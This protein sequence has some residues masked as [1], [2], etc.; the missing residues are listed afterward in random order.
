MYASNLLISAQRAA[1]TSKSLL[2]RFRPSWA[3]PYD[4]TVKAKSTNQLRLASGIVKPRERLLLFIALDGA[5]HG[6]DP[7]RLQKGMFLFAMDEESDPGEV[8]SFVPYNYGPMSAQI[9]RDLELLAEQGLVEAKPVHGQSWARYTATEDGLV[10]ARDLLRKEPSE[11][12]AR[13][14]YAIKT[15]VSSRSYK[16][17][18]EDV[19]DRF[20][21]YAAKSVFRRAS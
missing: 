1:I 21:E 15:D 13:R 12:A 19:Y 10:A 3:K 5:P 6:L 11:A 4:R 9:Y 17:V 7:I 16:E 20:P 8:Y 18:L 2:R 14:L